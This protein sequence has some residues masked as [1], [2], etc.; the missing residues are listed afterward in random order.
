MPT[1]ETM[2]TGVTGGHSLFDEADLNLVRVY[3]QVALHKDDDVRSSH[4]F[5]G[6]GLF[7]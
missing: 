3:F 2:L 6:D 5:R 7:S 1:M 4:N